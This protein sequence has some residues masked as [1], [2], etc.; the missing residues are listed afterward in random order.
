MLWSCDAMSTQEHQR[1]VVSWV[2]HVEVREYH[3]SR[4]LGA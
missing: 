3:T 4:S 2:E 1:S